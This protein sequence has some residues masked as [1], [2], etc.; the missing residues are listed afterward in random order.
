VDGFPEVFAVGDSAWIT[1]T[2]TNALLP[3]L[4]SVALQSGEHAGENIANLLRGEAVEPFKYTDKGTMA[5]IGHKSAVL[6]MPGGKTIKGKMAAL[7][8]GFVHLALMSGNDSRTKTM[9]D[10]GWSAFGHKRTERIDV[11]SQ[12]E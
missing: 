9:V 5:T 4:G 3:Q 11:D 1:D 2:K 7:A 12:A 6:Q 10:W 8:W